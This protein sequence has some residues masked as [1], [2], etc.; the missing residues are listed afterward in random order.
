MSIIAKYRGKKG[1]DYIFEYLDVDSF[2][3]L[4]KTK[5]TQV[6]AVCFC[7]GKMIIVFNGHNITWGLIGGTIEKG[8]SFEETLKREIQEESV[9]CTHIWRFLLQWR[10][11]HTYG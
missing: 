1:V 4:E 11:E 6:Y 8:E 5:C 7:E 9:M 2:E 10:N 3:N